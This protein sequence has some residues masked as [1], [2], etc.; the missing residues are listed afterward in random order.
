MSSVEMEE[1]ESQNHQQ[2][3][4][5]VPTVCHGVRCYTFYLIESLQQLDGMVL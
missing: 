2:Q 3:N 1:G 5:L 4:L